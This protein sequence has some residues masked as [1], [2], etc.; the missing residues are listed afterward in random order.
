MYF[1]DNLLTADPTSVT[2]D[3]LSVRLISKTE[4]SDEQKKFTW[5]T[6]QFTHH[7]LRLQLHFESPLAISSEGIKNRDVLEVRIKNP[8]LFRSEESK[9]IIP[10]GNLV[11]TFIPQQIS[12]GQAKSLEA[13]MTVAQVGTKTS[14]AATAGILLSKG[15][16]SDIW[17]MVNAI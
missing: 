9:E 6:I 5:K 12:V 13:V 10:R 8:F 4:V 1:T 15:L 17:G 11:T 14:F 7:Y 3:S 2:K 16:L